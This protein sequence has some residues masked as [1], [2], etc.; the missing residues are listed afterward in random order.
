M[1]LGLGLGF[2]PNP[3]PNPNQAEGGQAFHVVVD[4]ARVARVCARRALA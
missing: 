3:N 1:G 2:Y 4:G